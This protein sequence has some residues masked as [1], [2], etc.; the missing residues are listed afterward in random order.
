MN[1]TKKALSFARSPALDFWYLP[2]AFAWFTAGLCVLLALTKVVH[3]AYRSSSGIVGWIAYHHYPKQQELFWFLAAFAGLPVLIITG[4]TL[5]GFGAVALARLA[6]R[7]PVR[8]LKLLAMLHLPVLL[9][10]SR[11][12]QLRTDA[13]RM[14]LPAIGVT[15]LVSAASILRFRF[16]DPFFA[17]DGDIEPAILPDK[18]E[19]TPK[20]AGPSSAAWRTLSVIAFF[21][22]VPILLYFLRLNINTRTGTDL[23]EEAEFLLPTDMMLHGAIPYRDVYLQHGFLYNAGIPLLGAKLF[24]PTLSGLQMI[25]G[26]VEPFGLVAFYYLLIAACRNRLLVAAAMI[27]LASAMWVPSRAAFGMLSLA[28]LAAFLQPP[29]GFGIL[30][31]AEGKIDPP[32]KPRGLLRLCVRQGWPFL[33]S[34]FLAMLAFLHS[35]DVGIFSLCSIALFLAT[36]SIF[37][38]GIRVWRRVLPVSLFMS[39]GV[40]AILPFASYLVLHRGLADFLHNVW[41][42]CVYENDTWGLPFPNFFDAFQP[43]L[44]G[45]PHQKWADWLIAGDLRW[46]Y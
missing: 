37:Q 30:M 18:P 27:F 24:G 23:F 4:C 31:P 17:D 12:V 8:M 3:F 25:R 16:L 22:A 42:Q 40:I 21:V 2:V 29:R 1:S 34:G 39:G 10:W 45:F 9:A 35:V 11:L 41:V 14:V 5:W 28:V 46:Y 6:R 43:L 20:Q 32:P 15:V 19:A 36:V 33:L 38:R 7:S 44:A 26:Y 13:W